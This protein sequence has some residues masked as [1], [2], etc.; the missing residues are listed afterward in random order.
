L[1]AQSVPIVPMLTARFGSDLAGAAPGGAKHRVFRLA[2]VMPYFPHISQRWPVKYN[3]VPG[4]IGVFEAA[5]KPMPIGQT[6]WQTWAGNGLAAW[7]T[8]IRKQEIAGRWVIV[9]QEF[10]PAQ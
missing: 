10:R 2:H 6:T 5:D 8:R 1:T 9:H 4:S 3:Q 7:T